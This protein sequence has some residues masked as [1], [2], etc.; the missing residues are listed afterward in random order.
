RLA[1]HDDVG[2]IHRIHDVTVLEEIAHLVDYH[3]G[4]IVLGL[5]RGSPEVRKR[6]HVRVA[7][8]FFRG[9][10][11]YVI[12]DA[13]G[14]KPFEHGI[15]VDDAI[16][17]KVEE[18]C[19]ILHE[20]DPLVIDHLA[21]D[22]KERY[23]Q[24]HEVRR[25]ENFLD[26]VGFLDLG[27]QAPCRVDGDVRIVPEHVHAE[28]DGGVGHEAA[29]LAQPHH[30]DGMAG[31]PQPPATPLFPPPPPLPRPALALHPA[32]ATPPTPPPA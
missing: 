28:L 9:E 2:E 30:A 22:V 10:I 23:V 29:D 6:H 3:D 16:A 25:S 5:A 21:G 8:E 14:C 7:L 13:L 12:A 15:L 11:A 27:R 17:R 32:P 20:L 31:Q 19:T 4:G 1:R 18:D 24:G 26:A